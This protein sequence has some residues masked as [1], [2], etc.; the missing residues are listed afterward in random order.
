MKLPHYILSDLYD[1][2]PPATTYILTNIHLVD[3]TLDWDGPAELWIE[4]GM[5]HK[6]D[7]PNSF[8]SKAAEER[9]EVFDGQSYLCVPGLVDIHT[10][11]REPGFEYKET[12]ASGTLSAAAGGFTSILCMAN[13]NPVNDNPFVTQFIKSQVEKTGA[14]RVYPVGALS[15]GLKGL[16]LAEIGKMHEVGIVA[17]SDDGLPVM[18]SYLMRKAL[19]YCKTFQLSIISH[20]EDSN[21]VGQ[22]VMNEGF[23]SHCLGLRGIPA[24]SEEIL[25]SRDIVLSRLTKGKVHFAHLSTKQALL[26]V[27]RAKQEGLPITC[28]VTPHHLFFTEEDV[29][30]YDTNFKMAPPLRT[31]EDKEALQNALKNGTV[32]CIATDHAPHTPSDKDTLFEFASNGVIGLETAWCVGLS[33]VNQGVCSIFRLVDLMSCTPARLM[34]LPAGS[35]K[36]GSNADF[37][38]SDVQTQ[39]TFLNFYSKSKNSPFLDKTLK[40][41]VIATFVGGKCKWPL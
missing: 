29:K 17:V 6:I 3:P 13:T 25:V 41:K 31:I 4:N 11:L 24:A 27:N 33:L 34:G 23:H 20:A 16:E 10:H 14:V 15:K 9:P 26:Q 1:A 18:N 39:N 19:D 35:L 5:I 12:I 38:L 2:N 40:G 30:S 32:D 28:E 7:V 37:M 21:L 22:G 36:P 8:S